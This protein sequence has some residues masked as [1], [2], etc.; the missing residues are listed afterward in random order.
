MAAFV[1]YPCTYRFPRNRERDDQT[2]DIR[3]LPPLYTYYIY[4]NKLE[5]MAQLK[6]CELSVKNLMFPSQNYR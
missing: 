5:A 1:I 6:P 3:A 2:Y 4:F